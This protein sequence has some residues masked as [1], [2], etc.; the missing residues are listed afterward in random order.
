MT[1]SQPR[2]K[3]A[4]ALKSVAPSHRR[5]RKANAKHIELLCREIASKFHPDKIIL[6][7]SRAYGKARPESDIDLLVVMP[8]EGSPFRQAAVVLDHIVRTVG[9]IPLDLLVRT[10]QQVQERIQM[11]DSFMREILEHGQILYE[12]DHP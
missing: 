5:N 9:V 7:G 8:F 11:G 10:P 2:K 1:R 6:F 4:E 12:A 3:D